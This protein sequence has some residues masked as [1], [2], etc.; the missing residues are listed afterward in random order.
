M[1]SLPEMPPPYFA[2]RPRRKRR[3]GR[4]AI[5]VLLIAIIGG[6]GL[7][8]LTHRQ[9]ISDQL[10]V[11]NFHADSVVDNYIS[12]STMTG[13]GSFLFLAS[14]PKIATAQ[15]FNSVCA[16]HEEGSGVLGCYLPS[17]KT[18]T[19]FD[20]VD[21]RLDGIEEVVAAHEMLH[22]AWDRMGDQER[23][24]L[25][26]LLN[27]EFAR[28]SDDKDLVAR[29]GYYSRNEPGERLNELHS[30]LGTEI[31]QLSPALEKYYSSYF[32]DRKALVALHVKSNA[33]FVDLAAK[34]AV[35]VADLAVLKT[36]I[37]TDYASY[38]AGYDV[39]NRDVSN[40]NTKA[41]NG[42]FTSQSE[43]NRERNALIARQAALDAM[44][45]SIQA[46]ESVY[47]DKVKELQS[48]NALATD[49]NTSLNIIPRTSDGVGN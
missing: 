2:V 37:E 23:N 10:T 3:K 47:E 42:G 45:A 41:D 49:L 27:A 48:L 24:E 17:T 9:Y 12:R 36:G 31:A 14:Q 29:M 32:S 21:P 7:W 4:T 39:L 1:S 8:A 5:S 22:A 34:S 30:I 16:N 6:S 18:I 38:N 44:F 19:L 26:P 20:V 13:E 33:V 43:F 28:L 25:A 35:L 40:F 11:W 15:Q 46:R